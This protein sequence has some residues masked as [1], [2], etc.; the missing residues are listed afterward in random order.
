MK[1]NFFNA[2]AFVLAAIIV[3]SNTAPAYA[4]TVKRGDSLGK[5]ADKYN[6]SVEELISKITAIM[7]DDYE[8]KN[9]KK[10]IEDLINNYK[11]ERLINRKKE[12]INLLSNNNLDEAQ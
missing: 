9:D 8:L 11:K 5:I 3:L 4:Y 10:A 6:M 1:K 2:A 7:A 12:I